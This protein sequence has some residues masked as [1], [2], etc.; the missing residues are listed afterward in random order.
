MLEAQS[1]AKAGGAMV[2]SQPQLGGNAA[3]EGGLS[4]DEYLSKMSQ[5]GNGTRC[6]LW[7][8][9]PL[10][11]PWKS[12]QCSGDPQLPSQSS[13]PW[14]TSTLF[15]GFFDLILGWAPLAY[16]GHTHY[17]SIT[18]RGEVLHREED[19]PAGKRERAGG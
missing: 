13:Y 11:S 5:G 12:S 1:P 18:A 19:E 7:A 10:P 17:D 4:P 3:A 16:N 14:V 2:A 15:F 9:A 6:P 8:L